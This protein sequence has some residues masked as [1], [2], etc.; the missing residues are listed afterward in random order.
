[1]FRVSVCGLMALALGACASA[2]S[3]PRGE[4]A[5][6]I[7][8]PP[9]GESRIN[10][11]QIGPLDVLKITVFQEPDLSLEDMTSVHA[12]ITNA[13][14]EVLGVENSVKSR[15]SFGGTAPD[16]VKAQIKV[17]KDRLT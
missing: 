15:T 6:S 4:E 3:L 7:F 14:F 12:G 10:E 13:V 16:N 9:S 5:Y 8:P 1:M 2:N 17:W 11:Y